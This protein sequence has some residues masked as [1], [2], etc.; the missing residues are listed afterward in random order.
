MDKKF[1]AF[2]LAEVLITL[3]IICVVAALTMP[4]L[5][6]NYQKK[7]T[8]V[9][10]QK[11]YSALSQAVK[12]SEAQNGDVNDWDWSYGANSAE[13]TE[14]FM[15]N[16]LERYFTGLKFC[17]TG[18]SDKKCGVPVSANGRNY[19]LNDNTGLSFVFQ[20]DSKG[21]VLVDT[22]GKQPPNKPGRDLFYFN[23]KP[24]GKVLPFNWTEGVSRE[25]I[26]SGYNDSACNANGHYGSTSLDKSKY[27]C[28]WL[29]MQDDWEIKDD[30]PW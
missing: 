6:A 4:S 29:I 9:R 23:I 7:Q 10:L 26:I 24:D 15:Q 13:R 12:L 11:A 8:V 18:M 25:D 27:N 5:I 16:Y 1:S 30:Y 22:N 2:T 3:G 19:I 17:S 14:Y 28:T 21:Y 20:N